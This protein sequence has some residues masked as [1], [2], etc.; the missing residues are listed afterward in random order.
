MS[1]RCRC[2]EEFPPRNFQRV[3]D[4]DE[5]S[6]RMRY[7]TLFL[8]VDAAGTRFSCRRCGLIWAFVIGDAPPFLWRPEA[9]DQIA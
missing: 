5:F 7:S 2:H 9:R 8:P 3:R 1:L 4:A 6:T